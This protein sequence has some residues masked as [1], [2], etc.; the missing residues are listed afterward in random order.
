MKRRQFIRLLGGAAAWSI[1]AEAQTRQ[2]VRR[3][4]VLSSVPADDPEVQARMAHFIKGCKKQDGS[5]DVIYASNTG[6]VPRVM[7][8][9]QG[10]MRRN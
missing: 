8:S 2:G 1:A 5:L 4:A 10:N 3:I 6:G 7:Q 9:R